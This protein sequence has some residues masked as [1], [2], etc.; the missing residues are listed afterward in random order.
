MK[1][2]YESNNPK[3][4]NCHDKCGEDLESIYVRK[5]NKE[6]VHIKDFLTKW[7]RKKMTE[8]ENCETYCSDNNVSISKTMNDDDTIKVI[9]S[10]KQIFALAPGLKPHL[11][12]FKFKK[13]AGVLKPEPGDTY[14]HHIFYKHENFSL[15]SIEVSKV[16]SL[17]NI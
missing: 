10:F 13:E 11:C 15:D 6:K 12:Y 5:V 8:C 4:C 16:E 17:Y 2:A 9:D 14:N 3:T 7:E 1:Y